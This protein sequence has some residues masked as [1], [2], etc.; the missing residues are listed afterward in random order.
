M[1]QILILQRTIQ[2][3]TLANHEKQYESVANHSSNNCKTCSTKSYL[4]GGAA[5]NDLEEL[6]IN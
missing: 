5:V 4:L 6:P 1:P 3:K 2:W